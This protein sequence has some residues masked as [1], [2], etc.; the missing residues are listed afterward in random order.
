MNII[1]C[2]NYQKASQKSAVIIKKLLKLKP[3][4]KLGL[5]TG[6]TP[7]G[8]YQELIRASD[9]N[10][11]SFKDVQTYNLDEYCNISI[12]NEQSYY[13]FMHKNL[14][15]HIY[16]NER[17]VHIPF[18]RA[19]YEK[20]DC[21]TYNNLLNQNQVDLQVLG[22]GT[23]GHIGFN[24]PNT[25][26]E[27]ET[28]IVDLDL[29]TRLDNQRFFGS[30]EAVPT[31]AITMG[32]KNIMNAKHIVLI[33][34]GVNKAKTIKRLVE[35]SISEEFPASILKIHPNVDLIIDADAASELDK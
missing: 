6:S 13:Y 20:E 17:N 35:G 2:E 33:A 22:I 25:S 12:D 3:N 16:I 19:G 24:E 9:N 29:Q 27:Q 14:F 31:K 21:M 7:I 18:A 11:I 26:F 15:H 5:A 8:L 32:I 28:F 23:N 34:S 1:I 10:E 30:L 4:C